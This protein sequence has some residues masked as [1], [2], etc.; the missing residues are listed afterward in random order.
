MRARPFVFLF[1]CSLIEH[2]EICF[3]VELHKSNAITRIN[4]SNGT[5]ASAS[6]SMT[7]VPN[8]NKGKPKVAVRLRDT[9]SDDGHSVDNIHVLCW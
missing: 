3:G 5:S 8:E 9:Y 6:M 1:D 4:A 7:V 2:V